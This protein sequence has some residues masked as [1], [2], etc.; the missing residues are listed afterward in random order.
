MDDGHARELRDACGARGANDDAIAVMLDADAVAQG[1]RQ[2]A[3]GGGKFVAPFDARLGGTGGGLSDRDTV[4]NDHAAVGQHERA[5]HA[6]R[7][8]GDGLDEGLSTLTR[9]D[10]TSDVARTASQR[11]VPGT[12]AGGRTVTRALEP[13]VSTRVSERQPTGIDETTCTLGSPRAARS[14]ADC[15]KITPSATS[16]AC[17]QQV[18][19][20]ANRGRVPTNSSVDCA[21]SDVLVRDTRRDVGGSWGH[22]S[23]STRLLSLMQVDHGKAEIV[24]RLCQ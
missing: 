24:K 9:H 22:R 12:R 20:S 16:S 23:R 8:G 14:A 2:R 11:P 18:A 4:T 17:R 19:A 10:G 7:D 1:D 5:G 6:H 13:D 21:H 15:A 3:T